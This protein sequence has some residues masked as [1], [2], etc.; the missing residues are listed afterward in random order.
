MSDPR[1]RQ[2]AP[3]D[4]PV[5]LQFIRD[6]ARYEQ[7][8]H[9]LDLDAGRLAEHLFG[10]HPAC[11]ALL[12][13]VAGQPAGFALWYQSYSTFRTR[14]CLHLEDLFV[15][16]EQRGHGLGLALLRATAAVAAARGCPRL[17]WNVLDWNEPAIGFYRRQGAVLLPDWRVCR[18]EGE[19][20][21]KLAA[22]ASA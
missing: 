20:L 22:E 10:P 16:P 18:L 15:R 11:G 4:V 9:Q 3:A 7:L 1:V 5:V 19:A 12:A 6:L 8:E 17:D 13:D 14:P 21:A 2:A